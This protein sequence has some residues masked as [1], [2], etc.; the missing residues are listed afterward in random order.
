[1]SRD[2]HL[3]HVNDIRLTRVSNILWRR[4]KAAYMA[5][6]LEDLVLDLE[7]VYLAQQF[8]RLH[9]RSAA[10]CDLRG[11]FLGYTLMTAQ[12]HTSQRDS[13]ACHLL[14]S[15]MIPSKID[16][17]LATSANETRVD[18]E[19]CLETLFVR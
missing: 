3:S 13:F 4:H 15:V 5:Q 10:G 19:F 6:V 7:A 2:E 8:D 1:V 11:R 14:S 12:I 17:T 9:S 18:S 16:F